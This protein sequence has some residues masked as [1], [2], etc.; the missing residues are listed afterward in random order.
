MPGPAVRFDY[1][2]FDPSTGRLYIAHMNAGELVMRGAVDRAQEGPDSK[3]TL[4]MPYDTTVF[5]PAILRL[6]YH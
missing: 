5:L 4:S 1:Q 2:T 6:A 3:K